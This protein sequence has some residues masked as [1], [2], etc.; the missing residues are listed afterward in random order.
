VFTS[1]AVINQRQIGACN[2]AFDA[3]KADTTAAP[4]RQVVWHGWGDVSLTRAFADGCTAVYE[5]A[6]SGSLGFRL[7]ASIFIWNTVERVTA[8][9]RGRS[10]G[11]VSPP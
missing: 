1:A 11:I 3:H 4:T 8:T 5:W 6:V 2:D 9:V 10:G 7:S